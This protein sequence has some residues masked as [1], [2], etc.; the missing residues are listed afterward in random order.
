MS[1]GQRLERLAERLR[2]VDP[3]APPPGAKIRGW[4]LVLAAVEQSATV[5]SRAHPMRRLVLAAVVAGVFVV[6]GAVAASADSLPDSALYPLKAVVENVRGTLAFSP[7]DRLAYHL[8]LAQTRLTEA[9]AMIAH[10]RLDLADKALTALNEQLD[11]AALVVQAEN[12]SDPAAGV[13]L[14]SRLQQ[15]IAIHDNQ[16]AGLQGQVTNP[17]AISSASRLVS[18][19]SSGRV[20]RKPAYSSS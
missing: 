20:A 10:H 14:E 5:R 18:L 1:E 9:E 3:I 12:A 7:A 11:E 17:A 19:S 2:A 6:V 8:E 16:L 15:A 4:N 13:A